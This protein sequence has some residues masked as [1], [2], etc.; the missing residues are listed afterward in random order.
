MWR[1]EFIESEYVCNK[2]KLL[3]SLCG[4]T[5]ETLIYQ[6]NVYKKVGINV[7]VDEKNM[8]PTPLISG[9]IS[10]DLCLSMG[11]VGQTNAYNEMTD[12]ELP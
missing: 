4:F 11:L 6:K 9:R 2:L 10:H 8:F 5:F 3:A 7:Q 1:S 12:V